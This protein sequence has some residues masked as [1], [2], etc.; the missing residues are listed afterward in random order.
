[1]SDTRSLIPI[2]DEQANAVQEVAKAT[3]EALKALRGVGGFLKKTLGTTPEDLVGYLGGDWLKVRRA[4]NLARILEKSKERLRAR[5]VEPEEPASLSLALP[6]LISASNESRDELQDLWARLLAA[7]ADP[8]RAKS[9]R[10]AFID[11]AKRM[12]PLDAA[13]M[14]SSP[15]NANITME[16][17]QRLSEKL[18]VSRDEI[19]V[20]VSNLT[21]LEMFIIVHAPNGFLTP[22]A[23]EFLRA[24]SD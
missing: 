23:R 13:V 2:S 20:S 24:I 7:A 5:H 1:M 9:F 3:Q 16:V 17:R 4:E 6:I 21:K 12:D 15:S 19:D 22:F 10:L 14:A 11:A 18:N 8:S